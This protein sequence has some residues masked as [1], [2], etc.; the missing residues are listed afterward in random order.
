MNPEGVNL[1]ISEINAYDRVDKIP[2]V[3]EGHNDNISEIRVNSCENT[4]DTEATHKNLAED[5][6]ES[7]DNNE[8]LVK[9]NDIEF[10][11]SVCDKSFSS[12]WN[13][14]RHLRTHYGV[15][16]FSCF[17]CSK[18]FSRSEHLQRHKITH[19]KD[20]LFS[21]SICDRAFTRL[22]HLQRHKKIHAYEKLF[23]CSICGKAFKQNEYLKIHLRTHI[24]DSATLEIITEKVEVDTTNIPK[25]NVDSHEY[26]D[27]VK[28][29]H[30]NSVDMDSVLVKSEVIMDPIDSEVDKKNDNKLFKSEMNLNLI[31]EEV[32]T[33]DFVNDF[34]VVKTEIEDFDEE[35]IIDIVEH[36]ID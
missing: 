13:L 35:D 19:T 5:I 15:K 32:K 17:A 8:T 22:E 30:E 16:P 1:V 24:R 6:N 31:H 36:R 18:S 28:A 7:K 14:N 20:K 2:E 3:V 25:I 21:C 12:S 10:E 23:S 27:F 34:V 9:S 33:E 29:N 26:T 11:C 4:D